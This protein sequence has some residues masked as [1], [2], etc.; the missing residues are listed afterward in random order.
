MLTSLYKGKKALCWGGHFLVY[1]SS[2]TTPYSVHSW[3]LYTFLLTLYSPTCE[4]VYT[5]LSFSPN[6]VQ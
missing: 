4:L 2:G 6:K 3:G 5:S 1:Q